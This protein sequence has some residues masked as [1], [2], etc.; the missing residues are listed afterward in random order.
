MFEDGNES[1]AA[2]KQHAQTFDFQTE[3]EQQTASLCR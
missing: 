1:S 3:A 2:A